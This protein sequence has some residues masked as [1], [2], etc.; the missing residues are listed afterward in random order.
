VL[1][2]TPAAIVQELHADESALATAIAAWNGD[3]PAPAAVMQLTVDRA[4]LI[5]QIA[6]S[7]ATAAAVE[8][9]APGETDDIKAERDLLTLG[10]STPPPK[11][12]IK[13]KPAPPATKLLAWY[14]EAQR[15]FGIRWQLLAAINFVESAFGRIRNDSG[16]GA[17]GP[18]QFEP[19]TWKAYGLGGNVH[20]ARDAI[21]GAANYLAAN[22]GAT[23]ERDALLHYNPSPLYVDAVLH[24]AHRMAHVPTAFLEYYAR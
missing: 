4:G 19:A 15:R 12:P 9:L 23:D 14:Q 21:M 22:N 3:G 1:S 10:R 20:D 16:A 11:G 17:Q 24:Y 18:M 5:R 2:S 6:L 13:L 7:K 8:R